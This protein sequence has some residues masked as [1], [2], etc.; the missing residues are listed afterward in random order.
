MRTT[1]LLLTAAVSGSLLLAGCGGGD[2]PA[3]EATPAEVA[4]G[5]SLEQLQTWP[6]TG[7]RVGG[8]GT[9]EKDRPVLVVKMDNT[10]SAAPQLGLSQADLVVEELLLDVR[11]AGLWAGIDIDPAWGT[12]KDAC[13]ALMHRG[14]LAKDT[15][16]S[17]LRLA[18]PLTISVDDLDHGLD[19]LRDVL[20]E[21]GGAVRSAL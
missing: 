7:E 18:S 12:G 13:L 19:Q 2:E 3:E 8:D 5:T 9:A 6:L 17:T 16:G 4:E 20:A 14:V 15:H 11:G 1:H 21:D 10:S